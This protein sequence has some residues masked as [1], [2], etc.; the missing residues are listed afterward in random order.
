MTALYIALSLDENPAWYGLGSGVGHMILSPVT[1]P[2]GDHIGSGTLV[3][4]CDGKPLDAD[5]T[6]GKFT[7]DRMCARCV[8]WSKSDGYR[9]TVAGALA[10]YA[11]ELNGPTVA[12][13]IMSDPS[14]VVITLDT[15]APAKKRGTVKLGTPVKAKPSAPV[16]ATRVR[17]TVKLETPAPVVPGDV[18]SATPGNTSRVDAALA[19]ARKRA[20][21]KDATPVRES[22]PLPSPAPVETPAPVAEPVTLPA[23]APLVPR[24][25]SS[26]FG[27]LYAVRSGDRWHVG[28]SRAVATG[29]SEFYAMGEPGESVDG[30][31]AVVCAKMCSV[32][33][34]IGRGEYT[35]DVDAMRALLVAR[36]VMGADEPVRPRAERV[37]VDAAAKRDAAAAEKARL[38][39]QAASRVAARGENVRGFVRPRAVETAAGKMF[40]R[41]DVE[42][43][44]WAVAA[45]EDM[46]G[47]VIGAPGEGFADVAHRAAHRVAREH[48]EAFVSD[49]AITR[50]RAADLS[51]DALSV[52]AERDELRDAAAGV[53]VKRPGQAR[54]WARI[55][56]GKCAVVLP[57]EG[58]NP[59]RVITLS[60]RMLAE[61][62]E[63]IA[64]LVGCETVPVGKSA[65]AIAPAAGSD[66]DGQNGVCPVCHMAVKI[67]G[68]GGVGTHRPTGE[69]PDAPQLSQRVI[70]AVD[71]HGEDSRDA[72]KRRNGEAYAEVPEVREE[73]A[74]SVADDAPAAAVAAAVLA[75]AKGQ[76]DA[77]GVVKVKVK[78]GKGREGRT[79]VVSTAG[80]VKYAAPVRGAEG[81]RGARNHGRGDG[82]AM[83]PRGESGYA[84]F[85]F[86]DGGSIGLDGEKV[87]AKGAVSE[88]DPVVG[89]KFGTVRESEYLTYS[90]S[91]RRAYRRKVAQRKA[92][93][94]KGAQ[95]RKAERAA[96]G[97]PLTSM[98]KEAEQRRAKEA[99][100]NRK[101]LGSGR[102]G[103]GGSRHL[104]TAHTDVIVTAFGR[105]A[106]VGRELPADAK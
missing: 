73:L 61:T 50:E 25:V 65:A 42:T 63:A 49:N 89:G 27:K 14:A 93:W 32:A 78:S 70:P 103:N 43:D 54:G 57:A 33:D 16:K 64:A 28:D 45:G 15:P 83:L 7:G 19:A 26:R 4:A 75:V 102:Y 95:T 58:E 84:G 94:S 59:E 80:D 55:T 82:V 98:V 8:N 21:K 101:P 85:K 29:R 69:T 51:D 67:T 79:A 76:E 90:P 22:A 23:S 34:A 81:I 92:A 91:K 11:A 37:K 24:K 88:I 31:A 17:R 106:R 40:A 47:A 36:G 12:D 105:D 87:A 10:A 48:A 71:R 99:R 53:A 41:F 104:S 38:V 35:G 3:K 66:A 60:G 96:K 6:V 97:S 68:S 74:V 52:N 2:G 100:E 20:A 39:R 86:D 13:V 1:N 77:P 56:D 5:R 44:V 72:A 18:T 62:A 46:A 30:P 9:D